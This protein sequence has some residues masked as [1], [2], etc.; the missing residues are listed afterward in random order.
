VPK[1][2][3][4]V[5]V[6]GLVAAGAFL[7]W[8]A[9]PPKPVVVGPTTPALVAR[10]EYIATAADC[11]AC[12]TT[13][14][15]QSFAGGRAFKLPFGTL[16]SPNITPDRETG[17]G[18][19]SEPDFLRA[20]HQGIGAGGEELYP[21]F[22]YAAYAK[23]TDADALAV[24]AYLSTLKPVRSQNR[25]N[26]LAFPFNQRPLMRVWKLFFLPKEP[27]K[28][29][30]DRAADWNRGAYLVTALAHCGECH[31]PR[32]LLYGLNS[33]E[34]M[35]GATIQGWTAWNITPDKEHGI[36]DWSTEEIAAYL[37]HGYAP[38]RGAASG[39][40]K[41]AVD[42]SLSRLTREDLLAIAVYLKGLKPAEHGLTVEP[43]PTSLA[44]SDFILPAA[45]ETGEDV[46]K[47][48]FEGACSSC[49]AYNGQGQ[50]SPA[51][52][53]RGL[54]SV[55]DPNGRNLIRVVLHGGSAAAP[56]GRAD[57]PAFAHGYSDAEIAAVSNYV[58]RHF[59]GRAGKVGA[60]DVAAARREE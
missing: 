51:T 44:A 9:A 6:A 47:R 26:S 43:N 13:D 49:H 34:A 25:A 38:G 23:M 10:G 52:A 50:Q 58:I 36:G 20:L 40:M 29:E 8:P 27:F 60:A 53:L 7:V 17:I 31:T 30:P 24:R 41:E 11:I 28:P 46:G 59:G 3:A 12:H 2:I 57:M 33:D 18:T 14:G 39:P 19:W 21:A 16:Y 1:I 5:I 45:A 4:L 42:Y 35:A 56:Q 48:V 37:G 32:N 22:P 15:G 54:R 55:N